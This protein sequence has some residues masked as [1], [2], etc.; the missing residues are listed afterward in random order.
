MLDT[1]FASPVTVLVGMGFPLEMRSLLDALRYLDEQ[2]AMSR[3]E[4]FHA[5][6]G[7]CRDALDG[8]ASVAEARD[9]ICALARRRGVLLEGTWAR[10]ASVAEMTSLSA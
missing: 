10:S 7:A 8:K 4:A 2:P 9:M 6:Y 5:A 1:S 3:D